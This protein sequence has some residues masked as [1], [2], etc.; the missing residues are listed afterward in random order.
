M[1][2]QVEAH[3]LHQPLAGGTAAATVT[4]EPLIAGHVNWSRSIMERPGGRL[5][6]L[7]LLRALATGKPATTIPCPAFLIRHPSAG[8]VLVDTG[9]HPSVATDGRQNFGGLANRVAKPSLEPGEDVPA[10]LRARGLEAGEIPV[11]VMTHLHMDHSSAIS[12]F[13]ESAFVL[14]ETE[15]NA[16]AHGPRPLMNGYRRAHFDFAFDYR[17]IDFD[18][19]GIDSYASFGRTFDLFGDGSIRL[20]F[21]PG[22]S[23]GHLSV[24]AHLAERDFVIGGDAT[25]TVGQLEGSAPMPPRPYDAHNFRR[26]LQELRLF[27]SQFPDAVITPGH[28]PD[29][30]SRIER[31]YG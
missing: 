15:W 11:V 13:P 10:Q 24:I 9:L 30:Y 4:V 31:S 26:S 7:K 25:Y 2:V 27:H 21:T 6:S 12:E 8:A 1:R 18:R 17:T 23:P 16:A 29:F 28:D 3:P 14:S 20:A 19:A 5:E 22:H